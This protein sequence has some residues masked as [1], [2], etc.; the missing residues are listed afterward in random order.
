MINIQH[1]DFIE[2]KDLEILSQIG[3]H[4]FEKQFRQCLKLDIKVYYDFQ[5][6]QDEITKTIDYTI[7]VHELKAIIESQ[8]FELL[9]TL[10]NFVANWINKKFTTIACEVLI[11]KYHIVSSV[12]YVSV[13]AFRWGENRPS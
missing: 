10:A 7:I 1:Y 3:V 6:I 8:T 12:N 2:I 5:H 11:K 13:R 9:E 4:H